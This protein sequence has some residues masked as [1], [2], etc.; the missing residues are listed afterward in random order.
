MPIEL[1]FFD[2]SKPALPSAARW[3]AERYADGASLD[4]SDLIVCV[5]GGQARRRLLELLVEISAERGLMLAPPRI[6]TPGGFPELLYEAKQPFAS[7]LT[8]QLA[9]VGVLQE[10]AGAALAPLVAKLPERGDLPAWLALGQMLSDLHRELSADA[11]ECAQVLSEATQCDGFNEAR[12]WTLL[13]ELERRYLHTLD[14]LQVWDKQT[15]RL[16]AIRHRECRTER[17]IVLIGL[18]DLNRAQRQM[19]D[20][21][22]A[23]VTALVFGPNDRRGEL[24]DEHGCLRPEHWQKVL[25]PLED[26]QIE[27]ADGL[28]D[29]ADAVV[30]A[31][32]ALDGRYAAEQIAIGVPDPQLIPFIRQRLEESSLPARHAGGT[33]VSRSGPCQL[34]SEVADY[35]ENRRFSDLAALVRHPALARL[36]AKSIDVDW[37]TLVDN[38]YTEHLPARISDSWPKRSKVRALMRSVKGALDATLFELSRPKQPLAA[39]AQP[40]LNLLTAVYGEEGLIETSEPDRTILLACDEIRDALKTHLEI[41]ESLA[42]AV[43]GAGALRILLRQLDGESIAPRASAEAIELLGWLELIWD[44]APATIVCGFNEGSISKAVGGDLFLPNALRQRLGLNDNDRRLARDQYA[45]GL[46]LASRE[47]LR[48]IAGRR[49]AD[50]DPLVPSRLLFACPDGELAQRT[51]RL[52]SAPRMSSRILLPGSLQPGRANSNLPIPAPQEL[53]EPVPI[54]RVTEFRDYLACPYRYYLRH[55]LKLEALADSAQELDA[56]Q[57]GSLLHEALM[58][59]GRSESRDS[60]NP[61]E[62]RDHLFLALGEL[63][64]TRFGVAAQPAVQVQI[65]LLKLRL[66]AFAEQQ[67]RRRAEGWRIVHV[68]QEFGER[69]GNERPAKFPVG[70]QPALLAGRVDRIDRHETTGVWAVLDYKSSEK[71]EDPAK[72]HCKGDDWVDLQLPLYRHLVRE[73]NVTGEVKLGYIQLPKDTTKTAFKLADWT[74]DDLRRADETAREVVRRI[75]DGV[76]WPPAAQPPA[77]SD[78]FAAICQDGRLGAVADVEAEEADE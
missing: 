39:W 53:L 12:R 51:L 49:S 29:Q 60:K 31:L 46:L 64:A 63:A 25:L 35:L 2:W 40:I 37:L 22:A 69:D 56:G 5:P 27:I 32:A 14:E 75:R 28:G 62:I 17:R 6:V 52:F 72:T 1:E 71:A 19:L 66:K 10:A 43:T 11:L 36:L 7:D 48:L 67:A 45:L 50:N 41:D 76:F 20:Q 13:S 78:D 73:L 70:G 77:F 21:V 24:F 4:L 47:R 9:W 16:F 44:D 65:E 42:P 59:F 30:R 54:F 8:Q 26:G 3:L 33:P 57:F 61:D 34:L 18:V 15:A 74:E 38:F 58:D 55:R 68:E 23:H